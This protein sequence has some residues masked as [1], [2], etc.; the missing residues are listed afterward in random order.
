MVF[1]FGKAPFSITTLYT[2]K[3]FGWDAPEWG[4]YRTIFSSVYAFGNKIVFYIFYHH[5]I[6]KIIKTK[7]YI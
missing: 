2:R 3:K 7:I 1:L 6:F 5:I 4:F